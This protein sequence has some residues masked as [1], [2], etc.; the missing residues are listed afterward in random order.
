MRILLSDDV[1]VNIEKKRKN[2]T[3]A[4]MMITF[5]S[6][7]ITKQENFSTYTIRYLSFSRMKMMSVNTLM[8]IIN[9]DASKEFFFNLGFHLRAQV[10]RSS[11][12]INEHDSIPF[13]GL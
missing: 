4:S 6:N 1:N 10:I 3:D 5:F 13:D 7:E 12:Q 2:I 11:E 9:R 8:R